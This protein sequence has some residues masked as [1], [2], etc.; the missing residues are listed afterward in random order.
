[1]R[2][3]GAVN[4]L[5]AAEGESGPPDTPGLLMPPLRRMPI[6]E[7]TDIDGG[8][9]SA[10]LGVD[11]KELDS[12]ADTEFKGESVV[13]ADTDGDTVEAN[14][15]E[16]TVL[17]DENALARLDALATVAVS[18]TDTLESAE[19]DTAAVLCGDALE[20][21]LVLCI[22]DSDDEA[23]V[24][25]VSEL[26][27]DALDIALTLGI[28][29]SNEDALE[30][31]LD[32]AVSVLVVDALDIALVLCSNEAT[33]DAVDDAE[34]GADAQPLT[35]LVC[36]APLEAVTVAVMP[37]EDDAQAVQGTDC[38]RDSDAEGCPVAFKLLVVSALVKTSPELGD[39]LNEATMLA[40]AL[41]DDEVQSDVVTDAAGGENSL[42]AAGLRDAA[43]GDTLN[44]ALGNKSK[45]ALALNGGL[46][47]EAMLGGVTGLD[48][49]LVLA[50]CD[51]KLEGSM[52]EDTASRGVTGVLAV[53]A[54]ENR[55]DAVAVTP[56]DTLPEAACEPDS[57]A[58]AVLLAVVKTVPDE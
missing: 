37:L 2:I 38:N 56:P 35:L 43:L 1:M 51:A 27:E 49:A 16:C 52:K 42:G 33:K 11:D 39:D 12:D 55:S 41:D 25:A 50:Y 31:A 34:T 29:D 30:R 20:A 6:V 5:G 17:A 53:A 22:S 44:V 48:D 32:L 26:V 57:S 54:G 13:D 24:L 40:V 47:D 28:C 46:T 4:A 18:R 21:A 23:L 10:A 15:G 7:D 19:K 8:N 58:A 9:D 45:G 14:E 3:K 36:E